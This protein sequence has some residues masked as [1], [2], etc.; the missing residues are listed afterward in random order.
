[1]LFFLL[2]ML[3]FLWWVRDGGERTGGMQPC[4]STRSFASNESSPQ[5]GPR[6]RGTNECWWLQ[7]FEHEPPQSTRTSS[8]PTLPSL[9]VDLLQLF[10][11]PISSKR[12]RIGSAAHV[13]C[14]FSKPTTSCG[15]DSTAIKFLQA[16]V[17][18]SRRVN[19]RFIGQAQYLV[20]PDLSATAS[21]ACHITHIISYR[22]Y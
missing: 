11:E 20:G 6:G 13:R 19:R 14:R 1:M 2:W 7:A 4:F 16:Y 17:R 18:V 9:H 10:T 21:V 22:L 3:C 8:P 15:L 12:G 5:L